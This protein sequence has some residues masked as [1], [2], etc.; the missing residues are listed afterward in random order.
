MPG[1]VG[2]PEHR[3]SHD[4]AHFNL[5]F[6]HSLHETGRIQTSEALRFDVLRSGTGSL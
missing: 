3:V 6:I 5:L 4:A 1:L 2:N